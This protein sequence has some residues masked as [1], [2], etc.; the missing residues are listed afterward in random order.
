MRIFVEARK[1]RSRSRLALSSSSEPII[2]IARNRIPCYNVHSK[3]GCAFIAEIVGIGVILHLQHPARS[4]RA[5]FDRKTCC[6]RFV[7]FCS[8]STFPFD[9]LPLPPCVYWYLEIGELQRRVRQNKEALFFVKELV[10]MEDH[11]VA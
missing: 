1:R 5:Q 11:A 2:P 4:L 7:T 9:T 6:V 10:L 8:A 3:I